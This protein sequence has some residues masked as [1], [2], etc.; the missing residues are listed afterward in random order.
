ME[1]R[2]VGA[3]SGLTHRLVR[4][5]GIDL[6]VVEAGNPDGAPV[7]LLHGFPDFWWGWR[8][9]IRPLAEAGRRVIVP[10]MRGYG[11]SDAPQGVA[12]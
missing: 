1:D 12:S 2:V 9:V 8:H 5:N 6:H 10:D 3:I 4:A 7:I 11:R